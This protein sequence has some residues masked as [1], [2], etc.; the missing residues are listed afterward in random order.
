MT[1]TSSKYLTA[2]VVAWTRTLVAPR[3]GLLRPAAEATARA[4]HVGASPAMTKGEQAV[5]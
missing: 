4:L 5:P 1:S 3:M 2:P